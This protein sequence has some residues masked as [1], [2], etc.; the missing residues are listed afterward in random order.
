MFR[1]RNELIW[2]ALAAELPG[3]YLRSFEAM[4]EHYV[5]SYMYNKYSPTGFRERFCVTMHESACKQEFAMPS[6]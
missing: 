5:K 4:Y 6:P 2:G 3:I 1:L